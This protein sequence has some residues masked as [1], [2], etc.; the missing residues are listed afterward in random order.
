MRCLVVLGAVVA[1]AWRYVPEG[2]IV[3]AGLDI[4]FDF[5]NGGAWV[6]RPEEE[7]DAPAQGHAQDVGL[8]V[9]PSLDILEE[10][11]HGYD[12]GAEIIASYG[13]QL[14]E[15]FLEG[16]AQ[17]G[18]ILSGSLRNN[19][20]AALNLPEDA[21][22]QIETHIWKDSQ[23]FN[24]LSALITTQQGFHRVRSV[25]KDI[26][27]ELPS[28]EINKSQRTRIENLVTNLAVAGDGSGLCDWAG[29]IA[30]A[31]VN[32][33]TTQADLMEFVRKIIAHEG[34]F[35]TAPDC[36]MHAEL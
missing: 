24:I 4:R 20:E 7:S 31:S 21:P 36:R 10:K 26:V 33:P 9:L 1:A 22:K 30:A 15:T 35:V 2:E 12:D 19:K 29:A 18:R 11:A 5:E 6:K 16:D 28:R 27:K 14:M 34:E 25:L 23:T 32:S 13:Q 17:A 3:D 8:P